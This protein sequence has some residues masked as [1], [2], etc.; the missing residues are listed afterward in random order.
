MQRLPNF[1]GTTY[2][3]VGFRDEVA[4]V[5]QIIHFKSFISTS[6]L[7]DVAASFGGKTI[8][9]IKSFTGKYI[10]KYSFYPH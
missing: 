5:G 6:L 10:R 2:R 1:Y 9:T 4:E 3:G 8:Y 7:R